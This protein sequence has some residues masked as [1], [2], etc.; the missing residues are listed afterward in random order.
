MMRIELVAE[1]RLD[2]CCDISYVINATYSLYPSMFR[3]SSPQRVC[4]SIEND[5]ALHI[6]AYAGREIVGYAIAGTAL[7]STD[8]WISIYVDPYKPTHILSKA[9][10]K[11]LYRASHLLHSKYGVT[12]IDVYGWSEGSILT[13]LISDAIEVYSY[14]RWLTTMEFAHGMKPTISES[15]YMIKEVDTNDKNAI[16]QALRLLD[17]AFAEYRWY[18]RKSVEAFIE[19]AKEYDNWIA[20]VAT[21]NDRVIGYIDAVTYKALDGST[22][23]YI[24]WIAVAQSYRGRGIGRSLLYS[25]ISK[26]LELGV[27]RIIV[28]AVPAAEKFYSKHG[29]RAVTTWTL[30]RVP[31]YW[32]KE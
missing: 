2:I 17:E 10:S 28:D 19:I 12:V 3:E 20:I 29:F 16:A 27:D 30:F 11:I 4:R 14:E 8:G 13:K 6:V 15:R 32:V 24:R 21:E 1:P 31:V 23:G 7:S 5:N 22:C 25:C 9:I 26:L 18:R